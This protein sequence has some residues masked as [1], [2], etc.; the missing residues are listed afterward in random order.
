MDISKLREVLPQ[1]I[2]DQLPT[3]I[4]TYEI[5]TP[6]RMS[7]FLGQCSHES[8]G[9]KVMVENLNYSAEG[10]LKTFPHHFTEANVASYARQPEKIA[11]RVYAG[12]MHNGMEE[13]GDGWRYRGKGCI[14]ITGKENTQAFFQAIGLDVDIDPMVIVTGYPLISA[15]WFWHSRNLNEL[16]DKNAIASITQAINGGQNGLQSRIQLVDYYSTL[17]ID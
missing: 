12:R 13:S 15:G 5:N 1:M 8:Q 3:I 6:L 14:Q 4:D 17:V 16:A 7:N 10:L 2:F 11:N 9:F